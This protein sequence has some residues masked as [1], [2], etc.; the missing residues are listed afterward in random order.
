MWLLLPSPSLTGRYLSSA[1]EP[2]TITIPRTCVYSKLN[3]Y[4]VLVLEEVV[5]HYLRLS[6][7]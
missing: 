7:S 1:R 4:G 2:L 6:H 5:V 3:K